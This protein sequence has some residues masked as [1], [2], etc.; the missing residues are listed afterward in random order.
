MAEEPDELLRRAAARPHREPDLGELRARAD[1]RRR[2]RRAGTAL[3][4]A[5][6]LGVG[7][8]AALTLPGP[9]GDEIALQQPADSPASP[10]ATPSPRD[11]SDDD[12]APEVD[13][14]PGDAEP[15]G[16]EAEGDGEGDA[17]PAFEGGPDRYEREAAAEQETAVLAEVRVG[18]HET[19]DRVV[20]EFSEGDRPRLLVEYVD[21]PRQPGSGNRV[22]VA[23]DAYLR[24]IAEAATDR[25]AEMYAPGAP[26][27]DG[28][29]RLDGGNAQAVREVVALGDFEANMQ[30]AVGVDRQRPFRVQVLEGPLRVVVDV[31]H[32]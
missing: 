13:A 19:Y 1:R 32:R 12:L 22:D 14:T 10:D 2:L 3:G 26:A 29:T 18:V 31:G 7:S 28:P 25:G 30:W 20:W 17:E 5:A 27:Y 21:E 16:G 4:A 6:V 15:E 24:L 11:A 9:G 8:A 23:G